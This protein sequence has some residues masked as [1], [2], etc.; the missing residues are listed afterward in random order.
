MTQ[1]K[2]K[3]Y[4]RTCLGIPLL[5]VSFLCPCLQYSKLITFSEISIYGLKIS[6]VDIVYLVVSLILPASFIIKG[7]CKP[8]EIKKLL[9]ESAIEFTKWSSPIILIWIFTAADE[10]G[11]IPFTCPSDYPYKVT[12]IRTACIIRSANIIC[13]WSFIL[14]AVLWITVELYWDEDESDDEEATKNI[15]EELSRDNKA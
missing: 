3:A 15:Q 11:N 10:I 2:T 12:A 1:E 4:V 8:F 14:F 6:P 7:L 13:M 5:V 9:E